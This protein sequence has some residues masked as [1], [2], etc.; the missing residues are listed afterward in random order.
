M[1]QASYAILRQLLFNK[2]FCFPI[3]QTVQPLVDPG[4][5]APLQELISKS[6]RKLCS[7]PEPPK[8]QIDDTI[9]I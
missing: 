6:L 8:D 9:L 7:Q 5:Q 1:I 2:L 3:F 4:M